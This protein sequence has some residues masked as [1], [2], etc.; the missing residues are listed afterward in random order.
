MNIATATIALSIVIMLCSNALING[1][2][3]E[4]SDKIFGFWGHIHITDTKVLRTSESVPI[5]MD[6]ELEKAIGELNQVS[7]VDQYT[8][9]K[10]TTNGGVTHI[11]PYTFVP[12]LLDNNKSWEGIIL[13]GIDRNFNW[14]QMSHYLLEGKPIE[15][16]DT[17]ASRDLIISAQTASRMQVK[18]GDALIVHFGKERKSVKKRF[19]VS[20]IYKTELEEYDSKFAFCDLKLTQEILEWSPNQITG[21]EVYLEDL[22]DASYFADIIYNDYLPRGLYTETIQEKLPNI[23]EWLELQNINE[24]II[25]FLMVIVSIINMA[26]VILIF[27]L[28][29]SRMIGILKSVGSRDWMIRKIFI[30]QALWILFKGIIIGN[31]IALALILLQRYG[32]IIRLDPDSYYVSIAPVIISIYPFIWINTLVILVTL[33]WMILPTYIITK[34]RPVKVLRFG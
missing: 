10:K 2:K 14:K 1:F 32:Q 27:I 6:K 18:V 33:L 29:R 20:A 5:E 28:D 26:T 7:F 19:K 21:Y 25:I 22:Q 13:K 34:I 8:Q 4:I 11:Q 31:I 17:I 9:S 30:M 16:S 24:T 12:G 23:F 3:S 15:F